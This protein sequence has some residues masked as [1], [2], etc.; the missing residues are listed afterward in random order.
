MYQDFFQQPET[1]MTTNEFPPTL[2]H[3]L[4]KYSAHEKIASIQIVIVKVMSSRNFC[5]CVTII[6]WFVVTD[7]CTNICGKQTSDERRERRRKTFVVIVG[8]RSSQ[9]AKKEKI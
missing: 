6:R 8:F 1:A 4:R 9:Q 2:V 7:I 5:L 3:A